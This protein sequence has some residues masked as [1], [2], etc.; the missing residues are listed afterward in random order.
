MRALT[1]ILCAFLLAMPMAFSQIIMNDTISDCNGT[2]FDTGGAAGQYGAFE[3]FQYAIC[4]TDPHA[5]ISI[6]L[7]SY[8]TEPIF[9][10][11]VI[12]DGPDNTAPV[13]ATLSGTS[14]GAEFYNIPTTGCV[15]I[16]FTS[17][18]GVFGDGFEL[19]WTCTPGGCPTPPPDFETCS[20]TF[21]DSGGPAGDYSSNEEITTIICPDPDST[22]QCI[23]LNFT[24]FDVESGFDNLNIYNG[25]SDASPLVGQYTGTTSPGLIV[26]TD[27]CLTLVFTSD[28]SVTDPGW[29]ADIFCAECG[30]I[31][32]CIGNTPTCN[33]LPDACPTACDLGTLIAPTPCPFSTPV[34]EVFCID[35]V[36][37]TAE[38]PYNAQAGCDDGNNMPNPSADVWYSFTASSN[39]LDFDLQTELNA[40]SIGVYEGT[41]AGLQPL[42]CNNSTNGNVDLF[43]AGIL[44]GAT[45][46]I[47]ISGEDENDQGAISMTIESSNNCD[48][49]V[50]G[51]NLV[52]TPAASSGTY[53]PNQTVSFCFTLTEWNSAAANWFHGVVPSFTSGWDITTLTPTVIPPSCDGNGVWLWQQSITGTNGSSANP[54]TVGPGF[55]YDSASGGPLDGNGENNF[56]DNCSGPVNWEFC[57]EITTNDCPP[58]TNGEALVVEVETYGDSETGSWGSAGCEDDLTYSNISTLSCCV[59]AQVD[60]TAPPPECD[61]TGG[62]SITSTVT[63][64]QT[65]YV[66]TWSDA[67]IGNDPNPTGLTAGTYTVT[68]EDAASCATI[69]SIDVLGA[70]I[71][72]DVEA[73]ATQDTICVGES[74]TITATGATDYSWQPG[75][76]NTPGITVSPTMTTTYIVTGTTMI[77]GGMTGNLITNGDFEMGN[78]GFTSD[79]LS[80][81]AF[82]Q[83]EYLITDNAQSWNPNYDPCVDHTTGTGNMMVVDGAT[84]PGQNVW[85]QTVPVMMNTDYDFSAWVQSTFSASPVQLQLTINGTVVGAG[86]PGSS[87]TCMWAEYTETWNSG[88]STN[89]II[90]MSST[91]TTFL[92]NDFA[93]DDISFS[94]PGGSLCEDSDTLTIFV[95]NLTA[96]ITAQNDDGCNPGCDGSATVTASGGLGNVTYLWNDPNQQTTATA[97]ALCGGNYVVT[98]TDEAGCEAVAQVTLISVMPP[99]ATVQVSNTTCGLNDGE[100]IIT[101]N[102]GAPPYQYSIDGGATFQAAATFSN[103]PAGLYNIVVEDDAACQAITAANVLPSEAPTISTAGTINTS[104]GEDNGVIYISITGGVQNYQ[105]SIDG[106]ATF[107]TTSAFPNLPPG[108]YDICVQDAIGCMDTDQ[109]VIAPSTPPQIDFADLDD[110]SSCGSF[111]GSIEIFA[112][113]GTPPLMYSNNNGM[114]YGPSP[115]FTGLGANTYN[116]VVMDAAGCYDTLI[117]DLIDPTAPVIDSIFTINPMCGEEDG[118][119]EIL[120]ES[121]TGNPNFEYSIDNGVTFQ[122]SN[123]FNDLPDGVYEIIVEDFFGCRATAQV[124]LFQAGGPTVTALSTSNATCGDDNATITASATGGTTPYEYSIDGLTY[125]TGG[126]FTNLPPGQYTVIVRDAAGCEDEDIAILTTDGAV[127]ISASTTDQ[128]ACNVL[129]GSILINAN[130]G[131]PPY[132]FSIDNGMNYQNS[133]FFDG[134]SSNTYNVVVMDANGC[135][136]TTIVALNALNEP[137]ITSININ[138]AECGVED[139]EIEIIISGGTANYEYSIDGGLIFQGSNSFDSLAAGIYDVVVVDFLGCETT[140]QAIVN[141]ATAPEITDVTTQNPTCGNIDGSIIITAGNGTPGLSYSID[142][143]LTFQSNST[144]TGLDAGIYDIIVQDAAGCETFEQAILENAGALVID[145]VD[146]AASLCDDSNGELTITVSGGT[147]PYQYSINNGQN[148]QSGN[149]FSGLI[150]DVYNILIEDANGCQAAQVFNLLSA[151]TPVL[152][153]IIITPASCDELN[154]ALDLFVTGGTA[155]YQYSIDGGNTYQ[156]VSLFEDLPSGTYDVIVEDFNGCQATE[157][158]EIFPTMAAIPSII[159]DGPTDFCF[160]NTVNLYAG[161]F[162]SY[163]WSTGDTTATINVNL[164]GTYLVT[165]TDAQGCTGVA[166]QQLNVVPPY[167]VLAGDDQIIEIG[168]SYDLNVEFP[169][170]AITY[171]WTGSDGSTFTGTSFSADAN[172]VGTITYIVTAAFNDCEITDEV[173]ITIIDSSLWSIPNAFSPNEDGLNET[174]GPVISGTTQISQFKVFN[175]WGELVHDDINSRWDGSFRGQR[176]VADV[177]VYMVLLTTFEGEEIELTGNVMLMR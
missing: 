31:P 161:E 41:C 47:Q 130:G 105:Y 141:A 51:A 66:F 169:N 12:Y 1:T 86:F 58:G 43:V 59:A 135:L 165:V 104:C 49:C 39:Q 54:G 89:A 176:Q 109:V 117:V 146:T 79:Y 30:S 119:I 34:S 45:Y 2:L 103:L 99:T 87:T 7:L 173:V 35:N 61:G 175:R 157:Q 40:A 163:L 162:E 159:A 149:V 82:T 4:P 166:Q 55:V 94:G 68:V 97:T 52:A 116:L 111:D 26:A 20:G 138:D 112:S 114:V 147:I 81:G 6:N 42:G 108:T 102:G 136:D 131:T 106:C 95:S 137:L 143:G 80:T 38:M 23:F 28:G 15:T 153:S 70:I 100:I 44:P 139:G 107:Q 121:G 126:T 88:T 83:G 72:V 85:C 18:G 158:V 29:S 37:A 10:N 33:V 11:L 5:C 3:S 62:N 91:S 65:P 144:F 69:V 148:F 75:G 60:L 9:D 27:S 171:T 113:G 127:I 21:Y 32:P 154:G 133:G 73:T 152:D 129:D 155:A 177:Y 36:G 140:D 53:A 125:Q 8:D 76:Q 74:V 24:S 134:L 101:A 57:W 17:D 168:D 50:L 124:S 14:A 96:Q 93:L 128:S 145:D 164:S 25:P 142:D 132:D 151:G 174:F 16:G 160:Y 122:G 156:A 67:T 170:P 22:N 172:A 150:P 84:T 77:G 92:G 123:T 71:P 63:G 167:S 48:F 19:E 118:F 13:I 56:G 46:Y 64:G 98:V 110:P 115:L 120:L 78:T 90:C